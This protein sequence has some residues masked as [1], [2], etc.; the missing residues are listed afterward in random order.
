MLG[1]INP[2]LNTILVSLPIKISPLFIKTL[3]ELKSDSEWWFFHRL[4]QRMSFA[5]KWIIFG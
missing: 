3:E 1:T 4:T 2:E 5:E